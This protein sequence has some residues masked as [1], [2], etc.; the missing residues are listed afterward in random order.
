[1]RF[2]INLEG[3]RIRL[4]TLSIAFV[5]FFTALATQAS[6]A[7]LKVLHSFCGK[8]NCADG[9]N[10]MGDVFVDSTGTLY[11]TTTSGGA[12]NA[13]VIYRLRSKGGV[14][15]YDTLYSFCAK[16]GCADGNAPRGRLIADASGNLYGVTRAGANA[17]TAFELMPDGGRWKLKTLYRFCAK[18]GCKDGSLPNSG[19][20]YA[21][22]ER[23]APYDGTSPLYGESDFGG[24]PGQG[25]VYA[26]QPVQGKSL[27]AE[28]VLH[29]FCT[30][31]VECDV[32]DG[33]LPSGGLPIDD[34][35]NVFGA[36]AGG[37]T[38]FSGTIF[39]L[40]PRGTGKWKEKILYTFCGCSDGQSPTGIIG[41]SA[42]SFYGTTVGQGV[43]GKGG[44][45]FKFAGDG[46]FTVLHAFCSDTN[47]ADGHQP[48]A[49]PIRDAAG[50]LFGTTVIG[51]VDDGSEFHLGG[52]VVFSLSAGGAFSVLHAFCSEANC[53]DGK[54]PLT[55]VTMDAGGHLF[56]TTIAGGKNGMGVV[57]ELTP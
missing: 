51:G 37:G 54:E 46:T 15:T 43:N 18:K 4:P 2:W 55:G 19:L 32:N 44:T 38:N 53:K 21:G 29:S 7:T 5:T 16:T 8:A 6:A 45:L 23:G 13:G 10:P 1:M 25:V 42:G 31:T 50:N 40:S 36:T 28:Y 52:G 17:G 11:G 20:I 27:W 35:G 9:T 22:A 41:D 14:W 57:Y 12:H 26:L 47:C 3:K 56:G 30:E 33:S 39:R 24:L 48:G 34:S 49:P